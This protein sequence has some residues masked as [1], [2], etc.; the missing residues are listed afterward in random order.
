MIAEK[1][2]NRMELEH[3]Y[4]IDFIQ[5]KLLQKETFN[6]IWKKI[7]LNFGSVF[8]VFVSINATNSKYRK[9]II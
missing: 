2:R 7:K 3:V 6:N 5:F 4:L 8:N 9:T 1:R